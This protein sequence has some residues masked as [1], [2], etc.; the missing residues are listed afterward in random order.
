MSLTIGRPHTVDPELAVAALT[1]I[2]E[3]QTR[4][5]LHSVFKVLYDAEKRHLTEYR[6]R[7]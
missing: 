4:P 3:R 6:S 2:A 5:T 1:Y 7:A